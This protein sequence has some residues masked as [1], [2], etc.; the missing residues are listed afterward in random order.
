[1][2]IDLKMIRDDVHRITLELKER[3]LRVEK[4]QNKFETLSSKNRS[5]ADDGEQHSQAYYVIKVRGCVCKTDSVIHLQLPSRSL[6]DQYI[7][8]L[9]LLYLAQVATG[10]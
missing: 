4:L 7:V 10:R 1:M 3:A 5:A 6:R 9:P 8:G 2:R